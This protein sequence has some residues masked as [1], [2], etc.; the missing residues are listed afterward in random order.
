MPVKDTTSAIPHPP[1]SSLQLVSAPSF[2]SI[3]KL[4]RQM[5]GRVEDKRKKAFGGAPVAGEHYRLCVVT[6][7]DSQD[8]FHTG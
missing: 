2:S 4:M 3:A 7:G 1:P 6:T 8:P 5:G